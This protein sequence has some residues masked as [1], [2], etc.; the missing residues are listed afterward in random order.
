LKEF[1]DYIHLAVLGNMAGE[2]EDEIPNHNKKPIDVPFGIIPTYAPIKEEYDSFLKEYPISSSQIAIP[3]IYDNLLLEPEVVLDCDVKYYNG[4][5]LY[6]SPKRFT[7]YNNAHIHR[8][9]SETISE[10]FNWGVNSKGVATNWIEIRDFS[11]RGTLSNYNIVSYIKRGSAIEAYSLDTEISTYALLY[12]NLIDWTIKAV[13]N[14]R[15]GDGLE[16]ML[17]ILEA[18]NYPTKMLLSIGS[19][20]ITEVG[21]RVVVEDGDEVFVVIYDK[22]RYR[23]ESIKAYILAYKTR[24]TLYDG[25]VILQQTAY[26]TK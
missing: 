10:N 22:Y 7:A 18:S 5:I 11:E 9:A 17:P 20:P 3:T 23:P 8:L 19:T 4:S 24:N 15:E 1:N 14:Q 16:A 13:N 2:V 6:I 12:N 26:L 21:N 25:M